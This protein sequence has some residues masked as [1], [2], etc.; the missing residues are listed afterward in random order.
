VK[1][2]KAPMTKNGL[3][4][5]TTDW[6]TIEQW[7]QKHPAAGVAIRTGTETFIALDV[8]PEH[9]GDDALA[10]LEAEHGRLPATVEA[11]TP[12]GGRH[13][14]FAAPPGAEVRNSAGKLGPGLDVRGE[15][16]YVVAPPTP[17][18]IF[19][20]S[21]QP[22]EVP[23]ADFPSWLLRLLSADAR[24]NGSA[25]ALPSK[26]EAGQRND[27]LASL[28]G[29]LRRRGGSE[30]AILAAL[31][32][33]NEARCDPPLD[34]GEIAA[35][36]AS[37]GRYEPALVGNPAASREG[38]LDVTPLSRIAMRSIEWL[39]RPLWQRS[40]FQL[41]V[42]PKGAGKGTYLAGLAA[43]ITVAGKNVV[44]VSSEDSAEIDLKPRL[45]AAGADIDRCFVIQQ[46]VRLPDHVDE[47]RRIACEI[48]ELGLY[49]IDPVAN[50]IGDRN[51][52]NDAEVRDAIAPLNGLADELACLLVGV[53]HPGKDRSRGA[54]AS[55]L[56]STAWVDTPRAVVMVA[57]DDEDPLTRHVQVVAGNRSLNGS[58]Q[59]F[60]IEAVE[61]PGLDE[62]ITKAVALGESAK[63]VDDLISARTRG[64]SKSAAARE[65]I[66][67]ILEGDGAQESDALDA[68][69]A[70]TTGL[71][72]GTI[73]NLR[74]RL[75]DEGLIKVFPE[76][77]EHGEITRW[78]VSRTQAPRP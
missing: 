70:A 38:A 61:V 72:A 65:L 73:K 2:N 48:G 10:A 15:G 19:E 75:K 6:A 22:E 5:A 8:D 63:S 33:E 64:D 44:F 42:G 46:H 32:A 34:D 77:D 20:I 27:V 51:A 24:R 25:L 56:G 39:E 7:W 58:A 68:R 1:A 53:R 43:R 74:T 18:Y 54:V 49:V 60:R 50:H 31:R 47:L 12:S 11:L 66:L 30:A 17:G 55:V 62:P 36:A 71:V 41:L 14:Y 78:L 67:D 3:S 45:V 69:I 35:I 23:L 4:E 13:L 21:S 76:K 57:V 28:A 40:A 9:G 16:G 52:N 29:S 26:I 59:A 37:I